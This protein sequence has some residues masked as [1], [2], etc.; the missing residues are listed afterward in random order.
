MEKIKVTP[1]ARK[2]ARDLGIPPEEL[3]RAGTG[4]DGGVCEADVR[5]FAKSRTTDGDP[6]TVK[7][8]P[9]ARAVAL[10]RGLALS[11]IPGSGAHGRVMKADVLAVL[12]ARG[13]ASA[14]NMLSRGPAPAAGETLHADDGKEISEVTPYAGTRRIIGERL[15]ASMATAPHIFFTQQIRM[16]A[17]LALRREVNDSQDV[18]TSVTDYIARACVL[19]LRKYPEVNAALLGESIVRYK[20]VNL[21]VAVAAA[22]GLIVPN[23][24]RAEQLNLIGL[25]AASAVLV[26][27]A[28]N[29]KLTP[30]EYTGGTFTISNLGMFGIDN[31]TAIINPPESAILSVS[32]TK[33]APVVVAEAHGEARVAVRPVMNIQLSADHRV[34]DGLLAAQF[35]KELRELLENPLRLLL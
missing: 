23:V 21:G 32:A 5:E 3:P 6:A 14:A 2:A 28:R 19:T 30:D 24:K 15:A 12:A 11:E 18:K 4:F 22:N 8:T 35:V 16:E 10:A 20:T 29:G 9:V 27:K 34:V 26:E 7:A 33:D 1:R 25:S 17:L 13:A 31:F